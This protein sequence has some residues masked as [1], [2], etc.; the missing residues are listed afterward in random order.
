MDAMSLTGTAG[1]QI[2]LAGGSNP[3]HTSTPCLA[4]G[5]ACTVSVVFSP[6]TQGA[7]G[8][9][10]EVSGNTPPTSVA[11]TAEAVSCNTSGPRV[12]P[13]ETV[14]D[15]RTEEACGTL[16][17]GP[18]EITS[19]GVVTFRAGESIELRNGFSVFDGGTFTG[20]ID[21][22]LAPLLSVPGLAPV[23]PSSHPTPRTDSPC[24]RSLNAH[25]I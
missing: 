2:N 5:D 14:S 16:A 25:N 15:T 23:I 17:A 18:Y 10:L 3:C 7:V 24:D 1:L 11:L 8:E 21:P 6:S 4:P 12:L 22:A 13:S 20:T 9:T 19:G